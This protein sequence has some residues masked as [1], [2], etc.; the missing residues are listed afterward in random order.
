MTTLFSMSKTLLLTSLLL[1]SCT[2]PR[3][4]KPSFFLGEWTRSDPFGE[5]QISTTSWTFRENGTLTRD[6]YPPFF[7]E[8]RYKILAAETSK[9]TL[10]LHG[11][12]G[13]QSDALPDELE[14]TLDPQTGALSVNGSAPLTRQSKP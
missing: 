7:A 10:S 5:N 11:K 6:G 12:E 14:L 2:S 1:A 3:Q 4:P 8:A 9:A 13:P